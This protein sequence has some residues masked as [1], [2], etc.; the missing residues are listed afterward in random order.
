MPTSEWSVSFWMNLDQYTYGGDNLAMI[1]A[2]IPVSDANNG[3]AIGVKEDKYYKCHPN[4][5]FHV[6]LHFQKH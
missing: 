5:K 1:L 2:T 4:S 3:M 6:L